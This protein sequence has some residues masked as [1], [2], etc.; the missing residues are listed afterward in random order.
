MIPFSSFL[1][2]RPALSP[3]R[4]AIA[5][6]ARRPEAEILAP[7]LTRATLTDSQMEEIEAQSRILATA[8][9]EN[10][11]TKGVET[12][13][14]AFPLVSA[15]G[16]AL[17]CLAG[18]LLRIPDAPTRDALIHDQIGQGE[19]LH[20]G[21]HDHPFFLNAASWAMSTSSRFNAV[22]GGLRSLA[23][24]GT[25]PFI[26]H[27]VEKAIRMMGSQFVLA[28]TLNQALRRGRKLEQQGFTL[29]YAALHETAQTAEEAEMARRD[30]LTMVDTL[31]RQARGDTLFERPALS[32]CLSSLHPRFET[33]QLARIKAELLP[34]LATLAQRARAA[35]ILLILDA[36]RSTEL[37]LSLDLFEA[38]CHLHD[39][40]GWNGLGF[41]VQASDKRCLP[42]IEHL[43]ALAGETERRIVLRLVKGGFWDREIRDAQ[44]DSASD[45]PVFTRKCHTDV[46]F[47]ACARQA[48]EAPEA[49][50]PQF[51]THN[52]RSIATIMALANPFT[53]GR[54]EFGCLHGMGETLYAPLMRAN[55]A[56]GAGHS[57]TGQNAATPGCR[58]MA[59][60]GPDSRLAPTLVRRLLENGAPCSFVNQAANRTIALDTLIADPAAKARNVLPRGM[61]SQRITPPTE[62]FLPERVSAASL[63]LANPLTLQALASTLPG[64]VAL[65]EALPMG[66]AMPRPEGRPRAISNPATH[67]D[68]VGVVVYA[69]PRDI[70]AAL[71][72]AE[73]DMIWRRTEPG[74]RANCLDRMALALEQD[75]IALIALLMREAGKTLANAVGEWREAVD[76]LRYYAAQLRSL[77]EAGGLGAPL[78]TILCI[79]PWNFPLASFTGQVAV[80]LAAGNA[81][82]AKPAEETPLIAARL[83]GL[84]LEAGLPTRALQLLPGEGNVGASLVADSRIDGVMFTGSTAVA[85]T[86]SREL[87]GRTGRTGQPVPLLS[88]TSGQNAMLVDSSVPPEQV[89]PDILSSAFDS[90]GQRSASLRVLLIQEDGA[91]ALIE[92]L[93]SAI[94]EMCI[95]APDQ[96]RTDIGPVI[97]ASA[98]ARV[99]DHV[100]R[101]RRAGYRVWQP[102]MQAETLR[103]H[104][105]APTLIEIGR[106]ADIG[107]EV[108]GPVLHIRRYARHELD[109]VIDALNATGY[110]LTFGVQSRLPAT[111]E[112][113]CA[114]SRAGNIYVNRAIIGAT[115]GMQPFGGKGLSGS[116]P[117]LGGPLLLPRLMHGAPC[118]IV[119]PPETPVPST[120]RAFLSFLEPR[121]PPSARRVRAVIAHA[122][123]GLSFD[124]PAPSGESNRYSLRPRGVI[125]CACESW[126][127]LLHAV[128]LALGTGNTV[129]VL[130]PDPAVEWLRQVSRQLA[131]AITRVDPGAL[132]ECDA[133]LI[134]RG[135]ESAEQAALTVTAR[136]GMV[137]PVYDLDTV[138]PEW[139]LSE[140]V[141]TINHAAIGGDIG[142]LTSR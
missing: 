21:G 40:A 17:L 103:G 118:P 116:G 53:P 100:E 62:L 57:G 105:V 75:Q 109:G 111:I 123:S 89:I 79:S 35:D 52:A 25:A 81:V 1:P 106:V 26:R 142:L 39:L 72:A 69:R 107:Q 44:R 36:G 66:A 61:P 28:E 112:R 94:R 90:A 141:V 54:Y 16:K 32:L 45:Y 114:R 12:M 6:A 136:E 63:D 102:D 115:I 126:P 130:A 93:Q 7:L 78:G 73:T 85:K 131:N 98:R 140:T 27:G 92:R 30:A 139:L 65:L 108:F 122:L 2:H 125:L 4:E 14:Q 137:V 77:A 117:K 22:T 3:T 91:D 23:M 135:A 83:L 51:G 41:T 48:L 47:I 80:A 5:H 133:M 33:T 37:E 24:R 99:E 11:D 55:A 101:M 127:S 8:L 59:P 18:T 58:I 86:I 120:A 49:L 88:D 110:A 128:G 19:W 15:E 10:A 97:S 84:F 29:A 38:L 138:R 13:M 34:F 113:A 124:L 95:G 87:L 68:R 70:D 96:F 74:T 119:A 20:H 60:I 129:L 132:P 56:S 9:R 67:E 46:S 31:G 43:I 76:Y 64:Q 82:I 104:F 134:Q 50:Y 121:D 42:V 71:N